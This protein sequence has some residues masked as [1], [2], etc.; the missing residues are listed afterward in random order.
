VDFEATGDQR[1][2]VEAVEALLA[3][4]AGAARAIEL[5]RKDAYDHEL[6]AALAEAGFSQ[7][8][9][10]DGAGPLEAALVVEAVARAGGVVAVGAAALVVPLA[11]GEPVEGP[12]A[13]CDAAAARGGA[14][15]RFGAHARHALVDEGEEAW[16]VALDPGAAAPVRS[17]SGFPMGRLRQGTLGSHAARS[18]GAGSGERLRA[19]WRVATAIEAAGAMRAA[20]DATVDY[21]KRRRQFGRAIGSFQAVQHRLARCHVL[22]EG[23]RWLALEAAWR[24]APAEAAAAAAAYA[25]SAAAELFAETHQLSGAMGFTREHDLHVWTLRLQALRLEL[26]GT[27]AH[28]RALGE[29]RWRA[30]P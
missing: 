21:A 11:V 22:V 7:V 5:A 24:R 13:L 1:A 30:A 17:S 12:V 20:L 16:L 28:R 14:P 19:W 4:H 27:D 15:V 10:A 23:S 6:E 2:I 8:A 3:R 25:G 26:G 18:L 29:A 9:L